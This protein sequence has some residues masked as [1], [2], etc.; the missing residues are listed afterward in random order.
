MPTYKMDFIR[1]NEK[2]RSLLRPNQ[3]S[4][5]SDEPLET[6]TGYR[7]DFVRHPLPEK[8]KRKREVWQSDGTAFEATTNYSMD[9]KEKE[10]SKRE[11]FKPTVSGFESDEPLENR[12]TQRDDYVKWELATHKMQPLPEYLPPK[13]AIDSRTTHSMDYTEKPYS[14]VES[15]KIVKEKKVL[16]PFEDKTN[17]AQDYQNWKAERARPCPRKSYEPL[18]AKFEGIPTYTSDFVEHERAKREPIKP[19]N[20]DN[21]MDDNRFDENTIYRLDYT[22]KSIPKQRILEETNGGSVV[23]YEPISHRPFLSMTENENVE[24]VVCQ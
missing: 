4:I 22:K 9:F 13:E 18:S 17:Y 2:P 3:G 6:R 16:E 7:M 21:N 19:S 23:W 11:N 5:R 20:D 24:S 10:Y 14:K 12:T 1:Y 8:S 15:V